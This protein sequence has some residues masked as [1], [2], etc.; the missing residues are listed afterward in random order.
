MQRQAES[1]R[2]AIQK[3]TDAYLHQR[4]QLA[5]AEAGAFEKRLEQYRR[6]KQDNPA[7]LAAIWWDEMSKLF[8][9]M[10]AN[11][12]IDLLDHYLAGNG[13]DITIFPGKR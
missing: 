1:E 10:K 8:V 3:E 11:G 6:L 4:V 5:K 7:I 2:Y 9:K 13:L 12:R